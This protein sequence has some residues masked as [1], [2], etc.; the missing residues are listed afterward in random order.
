M[1]EV[2]DELESD[3]GNSGWI[4][5]ALELEIVGALPD[6]LS[7]DSKCS[8]QAAHN[9]S[10]N[11]PSI[12]NSYPAIGKPLGLCDSRGEVDALRRANEACRTAYSSTLNRVLVVLTVD[13]KRPFL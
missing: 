8:K 13:S 4:S 10:F 7:E 3:E 1:L 12:T 2:G 6:H 9:H 5:L 11:V